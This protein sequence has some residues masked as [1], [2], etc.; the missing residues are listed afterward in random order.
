MMMKKV[1][2]KRK[3]TASGRKPQGPFEDMTASLTIR[4][5]SAL[6]NRLEAAAQQSGRSLAQ[7]LLVRLE[8]SLSQGEAIGPK[9]LWTHFNE[10]LLHLQ[11]PEFDLKWKSDLKP[12][13]KTGGTVTSEA[14]ADSKSKS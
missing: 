2:K 6:R 13:D 10:F 5:P 8:S 7:E 3:K 9:E 1:I 4:M 14:A 11:K 12:E